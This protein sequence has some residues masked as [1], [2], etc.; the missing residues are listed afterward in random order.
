MALLAQRLAPHAKLPFRV[1]A[2][3]LELLLVLL[4]GLDEP[5]VFL[6]EELDRMEQRVEAALESGGLVGDGLEVE[7]D[8][9]AVRGGEFFPGA[10]GE[11]EG[12]FRGGG[13]R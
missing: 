1:L 3:L 7:L 2:Q 5:G 13:K 9:A 12:G 11:L 8:L 4:D 6:A 10:A